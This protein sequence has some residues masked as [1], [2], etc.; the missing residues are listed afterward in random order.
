MATFIKTYLPKLSMMS[1][2]ISATFMLVTPATAQDGEQ[3]YAKNC[4][5]CHQ[6]N[7]T[8]LAGAFPPLANNPHLADD[9]LHVVRT[10]LKGMSGPLEVN[11]NKYNAMMPPMQHLS[12]DEIA[13]I[14]NHVLSS[15][16]NDFGSVSVADVD[17]M[18]VELGLKDRAAG[19]P[20]AEATAAE[21]QYKGA[22]TAMKGGKQVVTPGAPPMTEDEFAQ[23]QEIYFQ[24]CAGCHGV[25]RKGATGLPLTTDITQEKG[26]EYLKALINYGSP[27]GMPNWGTSGELTAEEVDM[28]ARFIQHEPPVPPEWGMPE[29]K[30]SW[31]VHVAPEDRPQQ[32]QHDYDVD[33]MFAVTLR[34][35]GQVA[36]IDGDSKKVLNYVETGYA[37]HISRASSSGRYFTT[38][39]RDGKIDLIDLYM[40]VPSVVAEI[41]IG[42]EAR[43]VENSRFKGYED[44]IA[45][46]GAYWPPHYVLMDGQ[47]LE[48]HKIVSTRGMTVDTQEYH[49]EPRVAAIVG[50]HK[51]PEFIVNVKETGQIKLVD[52]SDMDNLQVTTID[53]APFLH[54]GGWDSSGR[55]FLTAANENDK[56]A[57]VDALERELEALVD[58]ERIP[59]P[60]RGA[61]FVDPEHGP[62]WAT[63]ALGNANITLIG[64][65]PEGH[66]DNAFKV[67]R[68]LEG[69]GGGSLFIKT[70]PK[71]SNLW[72]DTPLNPDEEVSQSV[73]V[74]DINNLDAGYEVLPIAK[75]ADLGSGPKR[76]V[77]PEYNK[78][79][80]EV[81]F[82]VWSGMEEQSAIVIVD[83]KTRKLKHVIKGEKIVTPTGKFNNYNTRNEVY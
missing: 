12:D 68:I 64:T 60:G 59:H 25:L 57:V 39:G 33:N 56:I 37:V 78:A 26:T 38:I 46:A 34:D 77:Q 49:P 5:S 45:I 48:P 11:G 3:A 28:M 51:H 19:K 63:S 22:P 61:N 83:D 65:D 80:D 75:W 52:Y 42:L 14:A 67:A 58:V 76:I 36:I 29:M 43:S 17:A 79:G 13:A 7:G 50:S 23:A 15:W 53:A 72:V 31:V 24:R 35:A 69:Q 71:S 1:V 30:D 10:V 16:G 54:D 18:R 8:G 81:W 73:A 55:Y 4:Q 66:P 27:A 6:A 82:S 41:K 9:K 20:H 40:E 74:F 32:P 47:T 44:K 21:M 70:H 2:A 62:V